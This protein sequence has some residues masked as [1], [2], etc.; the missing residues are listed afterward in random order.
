MTRS[1]SEAKIA[2]IHDW[3]TG[4][5][6]GEKCLE[7][8]C[9][10]FPQSVL[11]TLIHKKGSLSP[12]IESMDIRTSFL[13]K[14]PGITDQYRNFLPLFPCAIE[15][16]DLS[17]Y[18][19]VLS[20]SHCVAK[21]AKSPQSALNIS[22]CHTPVR[23]AWKFFDE[24]F[25]DITEPKKWIIR[26][27]MDH[28]KKWDI[29][30]NN[31]I[32]YFIATSENV[33]YLIKEYY[34]RDADMIYPPVDVDFYSNSVGEGK[35]FYLVVSALE[36]YKRIDLAVKA[37]NSN[38]RKLVVIGKGTKLNSLKGMAKGNIEFLGWVSNDMLKDYYKSCKAL[39]FPGREDFGIVPVEV[40]AQG[41]PV[42]AYAEGGVLETVIPLNGSEP[43]TGIFFSEQ[44]IEALNGAIDKFELNIAVFDPKV[45]RENAMPFGRE[46]FSREIKAYLENK[47]N[48]HAEKYF[49]MRDHT[50]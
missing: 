6:G 10:L 36:P 2:I 47:W 23:Y 21:G 19:L 1:I 34:K 18:D 8:F 45:L 5:R 15:S 49:Q 30:S 7:V 31:R 38:G 27:I 12:V 35:D 37:F 44:T 29:S 20:S 42:I 14:I 46:R 4:M 41:R 25:S 9:E 33:K 43:P 22:Y 28:L 48:E 17:G 16:F 11:Y 50:N 39:I 13:Q 3:L 24:Y 40:Q 26:K 32:D